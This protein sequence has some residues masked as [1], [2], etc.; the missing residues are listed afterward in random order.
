VR[1]SAD[2]VF[3]FAAT[4]GSGALGPLEPMVI[5]AALLMA[6]GC[7]WGLSRRLAEYR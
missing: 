1:A 5:V 3:T 7:G 6:I 4:Q 2:P